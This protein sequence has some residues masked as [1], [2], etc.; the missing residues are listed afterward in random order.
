MNKYNIQ[1]SQLPKKVCM[2]KKPNSCLEICMTLEFELGKN[3]QFYFG[4]LNFIEIIKYNRSLS[5]VKG[6]FD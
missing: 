5:F 2:E 3:K 4:S 1:L 6:V